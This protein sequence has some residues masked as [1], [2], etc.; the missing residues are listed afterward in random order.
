MATRRKESFGIS[1]LLLHSIGSD[2]RCRYSHYHFCNKMKLTNKF[3]LPKEIIRAVS[4]DTYSKGESTISVSGLLSAP[5][6]RILG[7]E[8]QDS[9]VV[10]VV[11]QVWKI[12][13][14]AT[15]TILER[16]NEGYEDTMIEE[17]MYASVLGW[18]IS[19]Q[20]DSISLE[21]NTLKDYKVTS[22]YKVM[23]AQKEGDDSWEAQ[24]N[25]YAWLYQHNIG[26]TIDKLQIITVNR[27]WNKSQK[28][29]MG[30]DYPD[31]P[32]SVI[33]IPVWDTETQK[34]FIE[35]RVKLH[36]EAEADFLINRELP[37]CSEEER[38]KRPDS[39]RVMKKG[40]KTALRVLDTQSKADD[41]IAKSSDN[42]LTIEFAKGESIK[43]KDYCDVA[44]FC[45]QYQE[46]VANERL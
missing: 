24:L 42:N 3:K 46:E 1:R 14:T 37:L 27:D 5:R 16:A 43:C 19:G 29:R 11:D 17:R 33:D 23:K 35:E 20:T 30:N 32:I 26:K 38:W 12:L 44:E 36:Q 34:E 6:P 8:H 4:N 31:S 28:K 40:R 39:F 41:Y 22:V 15:H 18:T 45:E 2:S 21:E 25:C 13:G 9:I 10:D 7:I